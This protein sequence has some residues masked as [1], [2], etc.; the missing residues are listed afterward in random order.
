MTDDSKIIESLGKEAADLLGT[1]PNEKRRQAQEKALLAAAPALPKKRSGRPFI[2]FAAAAA[3]AL[4]ITLAALAAFLIGREKPAQFWV[5]DT[6]AVSKKGLSLQATVEKPLPLKF[7][8]GSQLQLEESSTGQIVDATTK[9]VKIVLNHGRISARIKKNT[10]IKWTIKAG[11]YQVLVTGTKFSVFW[12]K[13]KALFDVNVKEGSVFI[14]GN[15][16]DNGLT[17]AAGNRLHINKKKGI[18][19]LEP[20]EE[21]SAEVLSSLQVQEAAGTTDQHQTSEEPP[22]AV[23]TEPV[24]EAKLDHA[25]DSEA[26]P[27]KEPGSAEWKGLVH[28]GKYSEA[29]K[30]VD[31]KKFSQLLATSGLS[32]L[33]QLADAARYAGKGDEA[34]KALMAIRDRF[35]ETKRAKLAAFLLGRVALELN[36][37][38]HEG[39]KWLNTYL[40]EDPNGPL[41]EEALGRLIIAYMKS[42]Q[43][44]KASDC[45]ES[46]LESY[47]NGAFAEIAKTALEN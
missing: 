1:G 9:K 27:K 3:A 6:L 24:L 19:S 29:M 43:K 26:Q 23:D 10:G 28:Q 37:N 30:M 5:G 34:Q 41:A 38:P 31:K 25:G 22:Q 40:K 11:P 16:L 21:K 35:G 8:D 2:L 13:E 36:D 18:M 47:A 42:G 20:V 45:A 33:V 32:D 7:T 15:G 14:T 44:K 17:L 39:I 46:Y 12:S 4:L